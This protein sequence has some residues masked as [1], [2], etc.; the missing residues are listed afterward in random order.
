MK[1]INAIYDLNGNLTAHSDNSVKYEQENNSLSIVVTFPTELDTATKRAYIRTAN[2][3]GEF[4]EMVTDTLTLESKYMVKGT[5]WVGFE[6]RLNDVYM[7]FQPLKIEINSFVSIGES[8]GNN[9]Y[10]VTVSVDS[11][12]TL[13][14]GENATVEN[15][16]N[17]KDVLL[18]FGIPR[19][20]N[21]DLQK[22]ATHIQWKLETEEEWTNLIPLTDLE[23][24]DIEFQRT[25]DY[26]QYRYYYPK[27]DAYS[28][29]VNLVLLEDLRGY[30]GDMIYLQKTTNHIQ[31]RY[32]DFKT[33]DYTEWQ[34][35][36][37]L[38]DIQ[39]YRGDG[40]ELQKTSTHIQ[41]RLYDYET[42][43][44]TDWA[45]IVA[46]SDIKGDKGDVGYYFTPSIDGNGNVSWTNN[47]GLPNPATANV[48][49]Q[50]RR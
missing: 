3:S 37:A 10:T 39:G 40:L 18:K 19:G 21:I 43:T 25:A 9:D 30:K 31:C 45:N 7:R 35:L 47:G 4:I 24:D 38:S 49:G 14:A 15:I 5:L 41:Y 27:T 42:Q 12:E 29:W 1:V 20:A 16:G 2:N 13:I 22:S 44:Y 8:V 23:S 36:I 6:T 34:N 32:Y 33:E 50:K 48:K 28:E 17:G 11:V 46:L 26:I